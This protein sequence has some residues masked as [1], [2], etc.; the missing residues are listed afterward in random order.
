M[1]PVYQT[2]VGAIPSAPVSIDH[3]ISPFQ[4]SLT[5]IIKAGTPTY[6]FQYTVDNIWDTD[7]DPATATWFPITGATNAITNT[8]F[9][10]NI[11]CT[12]VRSITTVAGT[13]QFTVLQAGQS[14]V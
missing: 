1:R 3:Y 12:A 13:I 14:G 2:L 4:I 11:P 6:T 10:F 5:G 7:F 9:Q 8:S